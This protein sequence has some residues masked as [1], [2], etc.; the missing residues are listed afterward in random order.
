[1][2]TNSSI[3]KEVW[4]TVFTERMVYRRE[5]EWIT[6]ICNSKE[7]Y[8]KPTAEWKNPDTNEDIVSDAIYMK[9]SKRQA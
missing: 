3:E 4:C 1:M 8:F 7:K 5:N 6:T 9:R 2:S